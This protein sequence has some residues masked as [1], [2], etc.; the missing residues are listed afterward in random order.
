MLFNPFLEL[1]VARIW[2]SI[3]MENS[4]FIKFSILVKLVFR[5]QAAQ[6]TSVAASSSLPL[7]HRQAGAY[8]YTPTARSTSQL[9]PSESQFR[10]PRSNANNSSPRQQKRDQV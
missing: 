10:P 5:T 2:S 1:Y 3:A 4:R 8:R 9:K 7:K 6:C